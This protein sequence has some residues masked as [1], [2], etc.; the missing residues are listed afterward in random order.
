MLHR[1]FRDEVL[2]RVVTK[3]HTMPTQVDAL[4]PPT[5]YPS[6]NEIAWDILESVREV[7]S[8]SAH[9]TQSTRQARRARGQAMAALVHFWESIEVKRSDAAFLREPGTQD[10]PETTSNAVTREIAGLVNRLDNLRY[11]LMCG[12]LRGT[13]DVTIGGQTVTI[14]YRFPAT[15]LDAVTPAPWS[16]AG[17]DIIGDVDTA[18]DT[19]MDDAGKIARTMVMNSFTEKYL[20]KNTDLKEIYRYEY[21]GLTY[22][23]GHLRSPILGLD[24]RI[25]D[26]TYKN[27]AGTVTKYIPDGV[28]VITSA[29]DREVAEY[30]V[31]QSYEAYDPPQTRRGSRAW[32]E[33]DPWSTVIGLEENG[34]PIIYD[35]N[36]YYV[37]QAIT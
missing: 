11:F 35:P 9:R 36:G 30:A 27:S 6:P 20:V 13:V 16:T 33:N 28:V 18:K 7:G 26:E 37:F 14:N 29:P 25:V 21:G 4:F 24:L 3:I 17:T 12:A 10:S 34:L 2:T 32:E 22:A 1:D 31:G 15:H 8:V 23:S 5:T 19:I